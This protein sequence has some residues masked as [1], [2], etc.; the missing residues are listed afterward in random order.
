M[1][2]WDNAFIYGLIKTASKSGTDMVSG[3]SNGV[4]YRIMFRHDISP[5][6]RIVVEHNRGD[7]YAKTSGTA[8][9]FSKVGYVAAG[10][11]YLM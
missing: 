2:A 11:V 10:E 9:K 6:G 7:I 5:T 1:R 4:K 3:I 8:D